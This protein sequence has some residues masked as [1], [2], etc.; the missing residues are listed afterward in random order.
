MRSTWFRPDYQIFE[1][2]AAQGY[3]ED[4]AATATLFKRPDDRRW[5]VEELAKIRAENG[6]IPGA[7]AMIKRFSGSTLAIVPRMLLRWRRLST[8]TY[9]ERWKRLHPSDT[10]IKCG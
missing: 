1:Q 8:A 6:D 9:R 7:K 10:R 2:Q 4:A 3:Y 5:S